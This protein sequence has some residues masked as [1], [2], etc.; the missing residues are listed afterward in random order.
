MS[1]QFAHLPQVLAEIAEVAG[2]EAAWEL[3]GAVGGTYVH[4]PS[5]Q[6]PDDHWLVE[7]VGREAADKIAAHF[8]GDNARLRLLIPM[9]RD[10]QRRQRLVKALEAG[11]SA[12]DAAASAGV[13]VR[14]AHRARR[15]LRRDPDENQGDLF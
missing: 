11:M 4:I 6:M 9:A 10:A 3:A 15:R 5:R 14:T 13:H 7:L 2:I 12:P 8:A 1:E